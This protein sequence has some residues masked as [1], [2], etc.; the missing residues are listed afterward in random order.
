MKREIYGKDTLLNFSS[1]TLSL[2]TLSTFQ[3]E[4]RKQGMP[5]TD[6]PFRLLKDYSFKEGNLSNMGLSGLFND[7]GPSATYYKI[8]NELIR[9]A[10]VSTNHKKVFIKK[11]ESSRWKQVSLHYVKGR[12]QEDYIT[13]N[14][15]MRGGITEKQELKYT[16]EDHVE[17]LTLKGQDMIYIRYGNSHTKQGLSWVDEKNNLQYFISN[18]IKSNLTKEELLRIAEAFI[19]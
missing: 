19:R 15:V 9:Q 10:E 8:Q 3:A 16:D 6:Y 4:A 14:A 5:N 11:L 2:G 1:G 12:D 17:K 18:S 13:V 7:H